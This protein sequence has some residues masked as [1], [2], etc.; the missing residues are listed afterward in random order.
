VHPITFRVSFGNILAIPP[1]SLITGKGFSGDPQQSILVAQPRDNKRF[2]YP[3]EVDD[4]LSLGT[5]PPEL[6]EARL[7][8]I[9]SAINLNGGLEDE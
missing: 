3:L 6:I 4:E 8:K 2:W 7:S 5:V 9:V 1:N